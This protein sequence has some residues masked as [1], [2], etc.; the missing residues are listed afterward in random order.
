[1]HGT[2]SGNKQKR[3]EE[4]CECAGMMTDPDRGSRKNPRAI[5][6]VVFVDGF[7]RDMS[8]ELVEKL[9]YQDTESK[10]GE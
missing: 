5:V 1:M 6:R 9:P 2:L 7:A 3:F 4:L 8:L 10:I